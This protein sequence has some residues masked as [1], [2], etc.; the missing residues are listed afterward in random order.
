MHISY[1]LG[2]KFVFFRWLQVNVERSV[3]CSATQWKPPRTD[4]CTH[5][6]T[7]ISNMS[8][9]AFEASV[10]IVYHTVPADSTTWDIY[11]T[12]GELK[13]TRYSKKTLGKVFCFCFFKSLSERKWGFSSPG[14]RICSHNSSKVLTI[15][16]CRC[17]IILLSDLTS[18]VQKEMVSQLS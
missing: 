8:S 13:A 15:W 10:Q 12:L 11:K 6:H 3:W 14:S 4:L 18:T 16:I 7:C 2:L 5:T 17:I 1:I 9:S